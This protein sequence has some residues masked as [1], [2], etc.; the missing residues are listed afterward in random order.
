VRRV[1][2]H[3][4]RMIGPNC[5]GILSTDPAVRLDATFAPASSPASATRR[6]CRATTSSSRGRPT[7]GRR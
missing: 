1:R 6:T 7:R 5:L 4:M 2:A 3:G